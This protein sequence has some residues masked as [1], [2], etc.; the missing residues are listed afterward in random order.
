MVSINCVVTALYL[1][2]ISKFK[3]CVVGCWSLLI[4]AHTLLSLSLHS[5]S[6][7]ELPVH[8]TKFLINVEC[9]AMLTFAIVYL[10]HLYCYFLIVVWC[11]WYCWGLS[12]EFVW[13]ACFCFCFV[14]VFVFPCHW[15]RSISAWLI[16]FGS[17][18]I[19]IVVPFIILLIFF[20]RLVAL[21]YV[22]FD[23]GSKDW[24]ALYK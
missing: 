21:W 1:I 20:H 12:L 5:T 24:N 6:C 3:V 16:C 8:I 14:F 15:I 7:G 2:Y 9:V 4:V 19:P 23:S 10:I 11:Y 13:F 17:S 22:S 18:L